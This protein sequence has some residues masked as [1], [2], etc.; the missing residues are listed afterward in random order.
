MDS[1]DL[2]EALLRL[3]TVDSLRQAHTGG[4]DTLSQAL[5]EC[6]QKIKF[7]RRKLEHDKNAA[8]VSRH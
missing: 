3:V 7:Y 2:Q 6:N 4:A 1:I 5:E 8:K